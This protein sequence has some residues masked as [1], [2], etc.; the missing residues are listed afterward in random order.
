MFLDQ[1]R[2]HCSKVYKNNSQP[3]ISTLSNP[4]SVPPTSSITLPIATRTPL[5][6]TAELVPRVV[7]VPLQVLPIKILGSGITTSVTRAHTRDVPVAAATSGSNN[8]PQR[9]HDPGVEVRRGVGSQHPPPP[10][11]R[12]GRSYSLTGN[13]DIDPAS[14]T[15]APPP[16]M[17]QS[18]RPVTEIN[19]HS[20][21]TPSLQRR[22]SMGH[23]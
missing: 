19:T 9:G 3:T 22:S 15:H 10:S 20:T 14:R 4:D 8:A 21:A 12:N 23:K 16:E 18:K 17:F 6:M 1:S 7:L 2:P 13:S 5:L 11:S